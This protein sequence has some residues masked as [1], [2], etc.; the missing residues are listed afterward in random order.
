VL[1]LDV[2]EVPLSDPPIVL[3]LCQL[4]FNENPALA[5]RAMI[6]RLRD[7]LGGMYPDIEPQHL[8]DLR[9]DIGPPGLEVHQRSAQAYVLRS[10]HH[11]WWVLVGA[12]VATLVTPVYEGRQDFVSRVAAL[13]R[14]LTEVS[15]VPGIRRVGVRVINRVADPVTLDELEALVDARF[16]GGIA[17]ELADGTE[18]VH[19]MHDLVLRWADNTLRA[20][21]GLVPPGFVPDPAVP[22][23]TGRSWLLDLDAFDE[24]YRPADG[25]VEATAEGLAENVHRVFRRLTT[26]AFVRRFGGDIA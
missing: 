16:S 9:V 19:S 23:V 22:A 21:I 12:S 1:S 15:G 8:Q 20:R 7:H 6:E 13:R 10:P 2:P 11:S 3:A 26:D 18:M 4:S 14:A 24:T 17:L 5:E 25:G